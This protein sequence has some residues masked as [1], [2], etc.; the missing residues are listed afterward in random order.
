MPLGQIGQ[1]FRDLYG[2]ALNERTVETALEAGYRLTEPVKGEIKGQLAKAEVVLFD[3]TGIRVAGELT[4]THVASNGNFTYLFVHA[5]RGRQALE[6]GALVL[7][8]F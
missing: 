5:K 4:W 8:Q 6:S 2:Y 1:L 7:P 3:E